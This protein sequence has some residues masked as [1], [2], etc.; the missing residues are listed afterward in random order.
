MSTES[1]GRGEPDRTLR[2]LWRERLGD[3]LG[4]RGPKQRS[5]VD[6]V[7]DAAIQIADEEGIE[8]LSM[9]RVADRL[10]LKP[11]SVY[12]YVPGKAEL[13]D[14]MVD[15]AAGEAPRP[16]LEG[17]L[18]ERLTTIA[19]LQWESY[20]RHPWLLAID[21]SRPPLGP[22]VSDHWEWCLRAVDGIGLTDL[23]MDRIITLLLG[24]VGGP[25]RAHLDAERLR[26]STAESDVEWWERNAPVLEQ[27]MDPT[28]Y[29]VSGR[30]GQ[31]AGEAYQAPAD[32]LGAFAFGLDL[33]IDGIEGYVAAN[34]A[35][36]PTTTT[37]AS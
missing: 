31:A 34:A 29:P 7:V 17:S 13:I 4:S 8:A 6:E 25:A 36:S 14:L 15:R 22:N 37:A 35:G 16:A 2:L 30:V 32:P 28:R 33:V 20:L 12:T 1:T 5:S 24:F 9:R 23:D 3:P 11:M 21:T 19:R 18:R 27:I 10:G 26:R